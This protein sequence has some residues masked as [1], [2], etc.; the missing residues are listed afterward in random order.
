ML[1]DDQLYQPLR[2]SPIP[3]FR[4]RRRPDG[5]R[6]GPA[7]RGR[8]EVAWLACAIGNDR[9]ARF[10]EKSGW[11]RA[12]R[13]STRR[14]RPADHSPPGVALREAVASSPVRLL[15]RW[16][17]SLAGR[18]VFQLPQCEVR[19]CVL[20]N[21]HANWFVA[22]ASLGRAD[23]WC[24]PS[25]SG[26]NLEFRS[27]LIERFGATVHAFDPTPLARSVGSQPAVPR[28]P[29]PARAG[30]ADSTARPGSS[31]RAGWAGKT[32]AWFARPGSATDRGTGTAL[33]HAGCPGRR[34]AR[35]GEARHRG[36][37][38][39]V[40][41]TCSPRGSVR[42]SSWWSS[43]TGGARWAPA[44]RAAIRCSTRTATG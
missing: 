40:F 11:R 38:V 43:I 2:L 8:V 23:R 12:G 28:A 29:G 41:P 31:R 42:G 5:R 14:R 10:Y 3:R 16:V 15:K 36:R 24:S 44:T 22:T 26:R 37:R 13:R 30:L 21:R 6:G 35:P 4:R 32:S 19:R 33:S 9:A 1:K 34:R 18:D 25:G 27:A 7:P 39:R 17:R 20:G